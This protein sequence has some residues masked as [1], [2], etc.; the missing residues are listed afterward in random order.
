MTKKK[1]ELT[2]FELVS[3]GEVLF[4]KEDVVNIYVSEFENTKLAEK[5]EHDK[6]AEELIREK[7]E[8]GKK[9]AE[10]VKEL[11][12]KKY[13]SHWKNLEKAINKVSNTGDYTTK[14]R[15]S[16]YTK[17]EL[18]AT[19]SLSCPT[20]TALNIDYKIKTPSSIKSLIDKADEVSDLY[21][22]E[23]EAR[24]NVCKALQSLDTIERSARAAVAK[25][26]LENT[27]DGRALLE[28]LKRTKALPGLE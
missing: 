26:A 18:V 17:E 2:S 16:L 22:K 9:T 5:E 8:L 10:K 1:N 24:Y 23:T 19:F 20:K 11:F 15:V 27:G 13:M 12:N 3:G 28:T 4:T 21:S 7:E 14:V 25:H 6:R